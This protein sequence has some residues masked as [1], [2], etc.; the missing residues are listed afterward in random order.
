MKK[1]NRGFTLIE[2]MIVVAVIGIL[3]AVA[4]PAY[5]DSVLKGRRA[6]GRAALLDLMQQQE[7]DMTQ[8]NCELGFTSDESGVATA[9]TP[10]PRTA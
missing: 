4:F 7:R 10:S 3:A 2:L 9:T 5:T 6:E 1:K 8:R